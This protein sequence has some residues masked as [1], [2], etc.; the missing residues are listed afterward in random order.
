MGAFVVILRLLDVSIVSVCCVFTP[1][2]LCVIC[3]PVHWTLHFVVVALSPVVDLRKALLWMCC[4]LDSVW[5][6]L[7]LALL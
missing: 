2:M 5:D 6:L 7:I 3:D 4:S 1:T